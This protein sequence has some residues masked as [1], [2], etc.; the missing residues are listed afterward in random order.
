MAITLSVKRFRQYL[1]GRPFTIITDCSAVA[2][3]FKKAELNQRIGRWVLELS[4][5]QYKI[6]H[7]SGQY[8]RHVD[9]LSRNPFISEN[10]SQIHNVNVVTITE[11]DWLLAAQHHDVNIQHIR[12]ILETDDYN[13]NKQIFNQYELRGGTIY[14]ITSFG[15]R[16]VVP[17]RARMQIVRLNHDD[18]GHFAVDKTYELVAHKYW[19]AHMRHFIKKYVKNCLNCLYF[20]TVGNKKTR[21]S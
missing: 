9:A 20:K 19:F 18:V 12:E 6:V 8:M 7:R 4:E 15:L 3:T 14:K 21:I 13:A 16:W 5:Y 11:S 10:S 1:Y 2:H 17:K